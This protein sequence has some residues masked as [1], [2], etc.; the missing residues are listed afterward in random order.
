[1]SVIK[2]L[3]DPRFLG[4]ATLLFLGLGLGAAWGSWR[5]V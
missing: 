1:M 5:N 3:W 2:M 4:L